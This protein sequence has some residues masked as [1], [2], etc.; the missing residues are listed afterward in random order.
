V[1]PFARVNVRGML[2]PGAVFRE[3]VATA[4]LLLALSACGSGDG[5]GSSAP[6][7]GLQPT[8]ASIQANLFTPTCAVPGC[9]TGATPAQGLRLDDQ[10]SYGSLV[11]VASP[12]GSTIFRVVPG[13][14]DNSFLIQKLEGTTMLGGRMPLVGCCLQQ[15]TVDV[16]RKWIQDG[17]KP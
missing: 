17:A 6:G 9:H 4:A 5:G 1:K 15:V 2:H 10:F 14:P 13:D 11:G 12:Y 16:I 3:Q 7:A 8:L